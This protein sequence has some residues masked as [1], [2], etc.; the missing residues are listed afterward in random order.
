MDD[1]TFEVKLEL[2][3]PSFEYKLVAT[4]LY[5]TREDIATAA[6]DN[7][8]K[9]WKLCVYNGPF[10]MTELLED[11]K[12]VWSKNEEYWDAENVKLNKVNW[13][14]VA[15]DATAATMFD[16]GQ[17]DVLEASGD[18][19]QKYQ[20]KVDAG[21][22]QSMRTQ[23][24]G[25]SMLCYELQNGGI[26]TL[27]SNVKVRK[28]IAYAVNK[29]EMID[30]V[31]GRYTP[32]F[33]LVS[34][35]ITVNDESYRAKAGEPLKAE[36]EEYSGNPEKLQELFKEGMEEVGITS[37]ISEVTITF[38]S[39]GSTTENQ[40][41]REY[42][43]QSLEQNLGVK[44]ELNTVGD[45][46]MFSAEREAYNYDIMLSAWYSDYND[47]LD[48]LHIFKTGEY[49]NSYGNYSNPE[50]DALCDSL[51]G[52]QDIAKRIEIYQQMEDMLL[53][54]DCGCSPVY[55]ADKNYFIQNWVVDFHTSSFGASQEVYKTYI[56]R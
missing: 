15:E 51:A 7:W 2:A 29:E 13:F 17:L 55:Y 4:P 31:Y 54:Q 6:G 30:A 28:A 37:D 34:P 47:P 32:A 11:N 52:E 40:I 45:F 10:N 35:G 27:M 21:E 38:L 49:P 3:D 26:S 24:P 23:Y 19:I 5:P 25:T 1:Y 48:F 20:E 39:Y 42:I 33:G 50:F 9:D 46:S 56:Q 8:G 14:V 43:Q 53:I 12:M 16:N 41:E 44:V 22:I 36:Y 18:Y